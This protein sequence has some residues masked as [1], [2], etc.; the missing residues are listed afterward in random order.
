M[1]WGSLP[2]P[3]DGLALV[4]PCLGD[5]YAC[6]GQHDRMLDVLCAEHCRHVLVV[7]SIDADSFLDLIHQL[8]RRMPRP[9]MAGEECGVGT[10]LAGRL[11]ARRLT[12]CGEPFFCMERLNHPRKGLCDAHLAVWLLSAMLSKVSVYRTL[13]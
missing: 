12:P 3:V 10:S 8:R 6:V 7:C 4:A 2:P 5:R 11:P 9:F 1:E 13:V